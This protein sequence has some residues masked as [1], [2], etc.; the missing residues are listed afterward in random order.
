MSASPFAAAL[1]LPEPPTWRALGWLAPYLLVYAIVPGGYAVTAAFCWR[2]RRD[3]GVQQQAT[4]RLTWLV[5]VAL[6]LEVAVGLSWL[7]LFAVS[8]PGIILLVSAIGRTGRWR[9]P[10]LGM[11]WLGVLV[12]GGLFIRSTHRHHAL[13]IEL[14]AGRAATDSSNRDKL[15]WLGER[16]P[17]GGALF[18]ADRP[19][20]YLPLGL[21]NPLFLDADIP[22]RQT[23][24]QDV[25]R[26]IAQLDATGLR[27]IVWSRPL[28]DAEENVDMEGVT[29]LRAYV[30][31][32]YRPV[33]AFP[34]GDEVWERR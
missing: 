13:V 19:C 7:R 2:E 34:D 26:S 25:E 3:A 28:E 31:E 1:G 33:H 9:R 27:Y 18:A 4:M 21:H 16:I 32:R 12:L 6:L 17:P 5:G 20:V 14:P 10:L 29:A 23:R 15:L 11:A 30:H 24:L 8:M 22:T